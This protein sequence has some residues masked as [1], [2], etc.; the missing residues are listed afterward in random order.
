[1]RRVA[2]AYLAV[3]IVLGGAYTFAPAGLLKGVA[4]NLFGVT[5]VVA[6]LIGL[7]RNG[8]AWK[9]PWLLIAASQAL[10]VGGDAAFTGY[11]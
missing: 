1:M 2:F 4:Y 7:R 5:A 3:C 8:S 11:A 6:I 9:R 10:F